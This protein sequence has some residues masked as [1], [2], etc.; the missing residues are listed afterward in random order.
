MGKPKLVRLADSPVLLACLLLLAAV[1]AAASYRK[2]SASTP[3]PVSGFNWAQHPDT[4]LLAVP[5]GDCGCGL[6]LSEWVRMG[7]GQ[8]LHVL[9]VA[10]QANDSLKALE[11]AK[12]PVRS[13]SIL[14]GVDARTIKQLAPKDQVTATLVR[15]GH[16]TSRL[17]GGIPPANFFQ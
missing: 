17:E 1:L 3:P 12:L 8:R 13:V 10:S 16:V 4:L 14:S 2:A 5:P 15:G 6:S 7:V 11:Q 9:I